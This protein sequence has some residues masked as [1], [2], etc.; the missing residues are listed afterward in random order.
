MN[1]DRL[2]DRAS[3]PLGYFRS[4]STGPATPLVV[5]AT[6]IGERMQIGLSYRATVFSEED[7]G[8]VQARFID[9]VEQL[10]RGTS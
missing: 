9:A 8:Q 3:L 10:R 2:W 7:V 6:T 5:S 4:V 1:L